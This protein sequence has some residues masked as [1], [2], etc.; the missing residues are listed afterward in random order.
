MSVPPQ[1][2]QQYQQ[3]PPPPPQRINTNALEDSADIYPDERGRTWVGQIACA[4]LATIGCAFGIACIIYTGMVMC[5]TAVSVSE[6][7][8]RLHTRA[9]G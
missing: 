2:Y 5:G 4:V 7:K 6:G 9:Q 8:I 3:P 1:Q